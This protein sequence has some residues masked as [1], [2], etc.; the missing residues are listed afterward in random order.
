MR[1]KPEAHAV[2]HFF[3]FITSAEFNFVG[4]NEKIPEHLVVPCSGHVRGRNVINV[5]AII[6]V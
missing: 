4:N 3:L 6:T 2:E 1:K 5:L